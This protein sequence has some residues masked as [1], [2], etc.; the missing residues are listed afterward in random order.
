MGYAVDGTRHKLLMVAT[1]TNQGKTHRMIVEDA[2]NSNKLIEFL[3]VFIKETLFDSGQSAHPSQQICQS[4][5]GR[6]QREHRNLHQ[7]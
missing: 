2:F 4:L 5:A 3:K 7:E 6:M 1:V